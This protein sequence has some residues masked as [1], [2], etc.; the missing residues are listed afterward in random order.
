MKQKL[1]ILYV[2][3][4]KND[5]ELVKNC[6][7][8]S[9]LEPEIIAVDTSDDFMTALKGNVFNLLLADYS[10]PGFDGLTALKLAKQSFPDLPVIII[11]GAIGEEL[12]IETLKAGAT[13]YVLKQNLNRLSPVVLRALN[14][15]EQLKEKNK[16]Q[17]DLAMAKEELEHK[18]ADLESIIAIVSHDLRNPLGSIMLR[19]GFFEDNINL[20]RDTLAGITIPEEINRKLSLILNTTMAENLRLL[21]VSALRMRSMLDNLTFVARTGLDTSQ[22]QEIDLNSILK[23]VAMDFQPKVL[24]AGA[25]LVIEPLPPCK[26]IVYLITHIFSNLIDNAIKYRDVNRLGMIRIHAQAQTARIVYCVEDNG[27]GIEKEN[28]KKIFDNFWQLDSNI[29]DGNGMG[30]TIV[31]Y[32][33][34]RQGG[35]IWLE[36]ELGRFSKFFVAL[37]R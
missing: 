16:I 21:Q 14:E 34:E 12:A 1:L 32:L 6:L 25:R 11:S 3:D 22:I 18:N 28:H 26:S 20:I 9:N 19:G 17:M 37:P 29:N 36:S 35:Q 33:V 2:E 27:I 24:S 23:K 13:D 5:V 30:L 4:N 10:L 7:N 31:K 15:A 8:N